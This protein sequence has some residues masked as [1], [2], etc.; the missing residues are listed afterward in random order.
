MAKKMNLMKF[1]QE[2]Q[3]YAQITNRRPALRPSVLYLMALRERAAKVAAPRRR[4]AVV[5][6]PDASARAPL[7]VKINHVRSGQSEYP[8]VIC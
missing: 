3:G 2:I 8:F 4:L 7:P 5:S 6:D 1:R